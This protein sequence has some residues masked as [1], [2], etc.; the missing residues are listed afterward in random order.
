[1]LNKNLVLKVSSLLA[2][3]LMLASAA[4]ISY[5]AGP[6]ERDKSSD[7]DDSSAVIATGNM[8]ALTLPAA[9]M[10][11]VELI[12]YDGGS[13]QLTVDF[14][15]I[16]YVV[17]PSTQGGSGVWNHVEFSLAPGTY[18]YTASIVGNPSTIN[19]T[20]TVAAGKV[21]SIGFYDNPE[22]TRGKDED[23][24]A[25]EVKGARSETLAKDTER[26]TNADLDDLLFGVSDVTAQ[27]H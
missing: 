1:M 26:R 18:N 3:G 24:D 19:N 9:G 21:T 15:G 25:K 5:A 6:R 11:S 7:G 20:I 17:P 13:S 12:N 4:G 10:A 27:A 22:I 2:V 8:G 16:D 14:N 23:E